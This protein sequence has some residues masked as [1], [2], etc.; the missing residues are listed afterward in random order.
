MGIFCEDLLIT[1]GSIDKELETAV[2]ATIDLERADM[3]EP[4]KVK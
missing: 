2:K 3:D 4:G 1:M